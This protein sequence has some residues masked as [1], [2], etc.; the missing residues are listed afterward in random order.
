MRAHLFY[1]VSLFMLMSTLAPH[2]HAQDSDTVSEISM[3]SLKNY[4]CD[5]P[6]VQSEDLFCPV[7]MKD[8]D[9]GKIVRYKIDE[10]HAVI[11]ASRSCA[12]NCYYYG[13]LEDSGK[14]TPIGEMVNPALDTDKKV[15]LSHMKIKAPADVG[16][17]TYYSLN[18]ETHE[19]NQMKKFVT[20]SDNFNQ[21]PPLFFDEK[22]HKDVP[23]A[24]KMRASE[25]EKE[26]QLALV[27]VK[28][29]V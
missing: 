14:L 17:M 20:D 25:F 10:T 6:E 28:G 5:R 19:I 16:I 26:N 7:T 27:L 22:H 29:A 2:V 15:L 1:A 13:F 4:D 11:F 24:Y 12:L 23:G 18:F 8:N 3:F 9:V 21:N